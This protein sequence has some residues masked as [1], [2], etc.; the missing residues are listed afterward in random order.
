MSTPVREKSPRQQG[1]YVERFRNL[2]PQQKAK[3]L[4]ELKRLYEDDGLS[5]RQIAE[6]M[7]SSYGFM[8]ARLTEA[9]VNLAVNSTSY[10]PPTQQDQG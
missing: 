10:I 2:D 7:Q 8:H 3:E 1:P 6:R 5:I 9:G 4:A